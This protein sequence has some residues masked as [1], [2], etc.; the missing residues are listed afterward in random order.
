MKIELDSRA[1]YDEMLALT[2]LRRSLH[3][4]EEPD[5][6][7]RDHLPGLRNLMRLMFTETAL[8][9]YDLLD[10]CTLPDSDLP[11]GA[12]PYSETTPMELSLTFADQPSF[13]AGKL[14]AVKRMLE[15]AVAAKVL[16]ALAPPAPAGRT[17]ALAASAR[18][19]V[20]ALRQCLEEGARPNLRIIPH[21]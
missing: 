2:A 12:D 18:G 9:L 11:A 20:A 15:H 13:T 16:E 8:Q 6:L 17:T 14:L 3:P 5:P 7:T 21:H 10:N 4:S 19:A 1:I